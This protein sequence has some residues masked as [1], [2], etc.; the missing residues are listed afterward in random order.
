MSNYRKILKLIIYICFLFFSVFLILEVSYRFYIFDFYGNTF[1][2]L[3]TDVSLINRDQKQTI[4]ILG[5]SFTA[6]PNSYVKHI[7]DSFPEYNVINSGIP[8]TSITQ[9]NLMLEKR[10][11]QTK[12]S[13]IIYQIYVGNDLFDIKH[14][15]KGQSLSLV[16]KIYWWLRDRI[17]FIGYVNGQLPSIRQT[18][19]ND[20]NEFIDPKVKSTYD[21]SLYSKRTK[22]HFSIEPQHLENTILLKSNRKKEFKKYIHE[23][24]SFINQISDTISVNFVV[25]PHCIQI[26]QRYLQRMTQLGATVENEDAVLSDQYNFYHEIAR[27]KYKYENL[28]IIN[29]LPFLKKGENIQS[30]YYENDPHLNPDG[31]EVLSKCIVS[32]LK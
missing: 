2:A 20:T 18:L 11:N 28:N 8:G 17:Y 14:P 24:E 32:S 23:L 15:Y 21:P 10:I 25:I 4:L 5:D 13:K 26:S 29:P 30:M 12:P 31:Q 7:R 19:S 1:K 9:A 6:D 22:L 3:N 16:R 27:L